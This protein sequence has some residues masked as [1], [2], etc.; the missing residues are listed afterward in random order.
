M[1]FSRHHLLQKCCL[2]VFSPFVMAQQSQDLAHQCPVPE[3]AQLGTNITI[4]DPDVIHILSQRTS[5]EKDQVA[6]F[7]GGIT[8]VNKDQKVA[9]QTLEFNRETAVMDAQG[10]IHF[11][12][13]SLD[14]FADRLFATQA[15]NST[16]L[17]S[18][19][20][21][22]KDSLI[23][24]DAGL[25]W[26]SQEGKLVLT[27]SSFTTCYGGTPDWKISASEISI[28]T[29]ENKGEAYHALLEVF[30][31]PVLYLPY[32]T[33]PVTDE[34]KS[35]FLYPKIGSSGNSGLE[36]ATPYYINIA[37]N[38]DA[39]VT[40]R[41][42]SKRGTQLVTEFRYLSGQQTGKIN[43]EYL[44]KDKALED[45]TEAR[46][47]W[48]F[49]HTG[50]FSEN[51]RAHV[52]YTSISDDSYL[53]DIGSSHYNSNDAYLYQIGEIAYFG[54]SWNA[55]MKLQDF[56][57]LGNHI[58]S[59]KTV[60]QIEVNSFQDLNFLDGKFELYSELSRFSTPDLSQPEAD[61]FHIEAGLT[62]PLY[63][64]A[65]F[66]NSEFKLLQ[67]NYKQ[68]RL[69]DNLSLEKN[70]SR[71]VPKVR[72]HGGLNLERNTSYFSNN[73]KQTLEPQ[74]QYLYIP[75]R[76]QDN[77]GV[78]DTAILQD[79]YDGLFRDKRF[80]G[81]DRI[82]EA[83]QY[84]WGLTSRLLDEKNIERM[85]LSLGRIVYLNDSNFNQDENGTAIDESALAAE[86]YI[87]ASDKWQLSSNIQ[88]NTDL[89]LTRQSQTNLDYHFSKNNLV[90]INH[91]YT[92][93]L[94]DVTLE[95]LSL[96]SSVK[97]SQDWHFV[98]RFTQDLKRS[99]SLETYAGFQYENCC[100]GIRFAYQRH[101]DSRVDDLSVIDPNRD[102]FDSGFVIQF[103][104][105]GLSGSSGLGTQDMFNS[106]IF[107]YKRPY[108]LNN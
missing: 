78:Y 15:D 42:L 1:L 48:R 53:V 87:R 38:M 3:F 66:L 100:W 9:A 98:S 89:D 92:R 29:E 65:W 104:I 52:D 32:F 71:T 62:F 83:N 47:L 72:F 51:F 39:T 91:R 34:R 33:F 50:N 27:D 26:V 44:N 2:V 93:D 20:Y 45:N 101:I 11:Q 8:L 59:Y 16:S 61:R 30:D 103:V 70:V 97:I 60:P 4:D 67:T 17:T 10:D 74:L 19:T 63:T 69:G 86:M 6:I 22:L 64:P 56:E 57:V 79:N 99:R 13:K 28:S 58:Q 75:S 41:Y 96:L 77:I 23:H 5:I 25:L 102:E 106:S 31:V 82:A 88:Y 95:Q 7:E 35:G 94:S 21:Y 55:T 105:K 24:G 43:L 90:Q 46:Y 18:A 107:G 36:I 81:L 40:P 108:F 49:Q 80:S 85:R 14:I 73:Y 68:S 84:S 37:P 76:E 12:D 54:E